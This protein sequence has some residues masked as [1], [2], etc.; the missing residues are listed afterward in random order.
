MIKNPNVFNL[1]DEINRKKVCYFINKYVTRL[2][3]SCHIQLWAAKN[4][5]RTIFDLITMS[6]S[7]YTV[8]VIENS[9][10]IWQQC[11]EGQ[12]VSFEIGWERW[13]RDQEELSTKKTPKFM[14][15]S[16]KKRECNTLG[17]NHEGIHFFNKVCNKGKKLARKN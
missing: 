11:N 15:R 10:A 17:W 3:G 9:H 14:K 16:G 13:E 2:Y 7:V 12:N 4:K 5:N 1:R 8:A 6:D